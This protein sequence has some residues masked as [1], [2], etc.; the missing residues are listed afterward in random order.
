MNT[1][2]DV[3][4]GTGFLTKADA[5]MARKVIALDFVKAMIDNAT[6]KL[7]VMKFVPILLATRTKP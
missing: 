3:G 1:V 7:F 6:S 4:D 5:K 2:L